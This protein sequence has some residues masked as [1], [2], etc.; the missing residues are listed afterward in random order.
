M[1]RLVTD[2]FLLA[3]AALTVTV[4]LIDAVISAEA[5]LAVVFALA[6]VLLLYALARNVGKRVPTMLRTDLARWLEDHAHRTG[7]RRD[8]AADRAVA[9]YRRR[10]DPTEGH[11]AVFGRA[12][13]PRSGGQGNGD[14]E[15]HD[16]DDPGDALTLRLDGSGVPARQVG[17]KAA[18]LDRLLAGG[19][20]VPPAGV[21][22]TAA[23]R[24]FAATPEIAALVRELRTTEADPEDHDALRQR[25]DE[26]FLA[27]D[28]DERTREAILALAAQVRNGGLL[29]VRSSATAEDQAAASF[30]GQYRSLLEVGGEEEVLRAVRLVW[31]SLWSPAAHTYRRHRGIDEDDVAMAVVLMRLVD[32]A[33][34]GVAFT[35]EP[36]GDSDRMRL[37]WVDGL[38]EGLVSGTRTPQV[39][40][41]ARAGT[42]N[43]DGEH[44]PLLDEV[45]ETAMA[46]EEL[47]GS[48]QDVEWAHDGDRL[49]V[50]Q[51]RPITT[52][53]QTSDD[54]GFDVRPVEGCTYTSAGIG[55]MLPGVI[56]PL[57]WSIDG[58]LLEEGF[59]EL[60]DQLGSLPEPLDAPLAVIGRFRGRAALNLDVLKRAAAQMPGGSGAEMERQYFGELLSEEAP[61]DDDSLLDRLRALPA[62]VRALRMRRR[63]RLEAEAIIDAVEAVVALEVDPAE[64]DGAHLLAYW[65]RIGV[66]AT[67][68]VAVQ[69]AV[70]AAAAA[71]YRTLEA[72][73]E[74]HLGSAAAAAAQRLTA[75][76]TQPCGVQTSLDV[77]DLVVDGLDDPDVRAALEAAERSVDE[78]R[79]RLQET[80]AGRRFVRQFHERMRQAGSAALFAGPTWDEDDQIAW[81]LLRQA[82]R[83]E[84]RDARP[85]GVDGGAA[86]AEVEAQLPTG[87]KWRLTRVATGQIVDMR[88]RMLRRLT[89]DATYFLRLR[90][91]TKLAVLR[92][93]G[94]ARRALRAAADRLVEQGVLAS[95]DAVDLLDVV[96]LEEA[97]VG[98][99]PVSGEVLARRR[100]ALDS[101]RASGP[102]PRLFSGRPPPAA[103]EQHEGDRL[104]GWA[105][106]P[107]RHRGRVR[108]VRDVASA[109]LDPGDVL[110]AEATDPSWTP[111]FLTAGAIVVEQG[112]P[113]SHAAIVARELGV[114]A[115]LNVA[116]A[117][118]LLD[119]VQA[120]TVDGD[121][122]TVLLH[123][124]DPATVTPGDA[125]SP[126]VPT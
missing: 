31:A 16:A 69:V 28:M 72:F 60:F 47:F 100:R 24:R 32:A 36:S 22:T 118:R 122:G 33:Q 92:L 62:M 81:N 87:W 63:L 70:A 9:S 116:G 95:R 46:V 108:V 6:D 104:D 80:A 61:E 120:A 12:R 37:E 99:Q 19:F 7:Q 74:Q 58:P 73:L 27:A 112:G 79:Q 38:A 117:T 53:S 39:A 25:I 86:L 50:V 82:A 97:L 111:L 84:L 75:G 23:Y 98:G 83:V 20:P 49:W 114:P 65:R 119:G 102:L 40:R 125:V 124:A 30:A 44:P 64:L 51:A 103:L 115:V 34:A 59:R 68:T 13:Q 15:D 78:L 26:A 66:L 91:R 17:G 89:A 88:R 107:G 3:V 43:P 52:G 71:T 106:S 29:A 54:D 85:G 10:I 55:E 77:C 42:G 101:A 67:R 57:L 5:D 94:E 105:A 110:V 48:P 45:A 18:A 2:R 56:P 96:E 126:E 121:R 93:G 21:V 90:E 14:E 1:N 109:D 8:T 123:E 76:G 35:V 41:V 113:L 11:T 4:G